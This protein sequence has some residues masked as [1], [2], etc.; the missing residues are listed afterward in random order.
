SISKAKKKKNEAVAKHMRYTDL[1]PR[2]VL[3]STLMPTG[4]LFP[5]QN[6]GSYFSSTP[7]I[8][9]MMDTN[10]PRKRNK[11]KLRRVTVEFLVEGQ[12]PHSRQEAEPQRHDACRERETAA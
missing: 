1:S 10:V 4:E 9:I 12:Q 11:V 2:K 5:L 7:G 6:P 3:Q 8:I